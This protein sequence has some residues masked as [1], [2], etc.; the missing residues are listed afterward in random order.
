M[1]DRPELRLANMESILASFQ[2]KFGRGSSFYLKFP[3]VEKPGA[4]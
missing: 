1:P 2:N 3:C 4:I